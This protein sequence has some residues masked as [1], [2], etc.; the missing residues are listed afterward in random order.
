MVF[1]VVWTIIL[2]F[3]AYNVIS[4]CLRR[5]YPPSGN[6]QRMTPPRYPGG[7]PGTFP[8]THHPGSPP[9]P[10][11]KNPSH[12]TPAD[13]TQWRPGFWTGAA[14]GGLGAHLLNRSRSQ[15]RAAA[16]DW[17]E[18]RTPFR[19]RTRP[20]SSFEDRGRD[21]DRGEGSSNLGAM[22]SSTGYGGSSTR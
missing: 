16:Y 3:I 6:F 17:E 1:M 12:D 10:Y 4:S 7:G 19:G 18:D 9:P 15:P 22:R 2:L 14:L 21:R 8:G 13:G 20:V 5:N 11:T